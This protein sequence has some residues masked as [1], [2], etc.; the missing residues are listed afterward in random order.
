M[1]TFCVH[2]GKRVKE[3]GAAR[4]S[5]IPFQS[6]CPKCGRP[7]ELTGEVFIVPDP[8]LRLDQVEAVQSEVAALLV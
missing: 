4:R 3:D 1:S 7:A 8:G 5:G 6:L 2:C